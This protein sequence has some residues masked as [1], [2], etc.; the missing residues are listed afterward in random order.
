[1]K[2]ES[3]DGEIIILSGGG[4]DVLTSI[5]IGSPYRR[6]GQTYSQIEE[7][8]GLPPQVPTPR[9]A[10][11]MGQVCDG[12]TERR[13][14]EPK[15][16]HPNL[17]SEP[18]ITIIYNARACPPCRPANLDVIKHRQFSNRR[19]CGVVACIRDHTEWLRSSRILELERSRGRIANETNSG[20]TAKVQLL[21]AAV[22]LTDVGRSRGFML[23]KVKIIN[24]ADGDI[25][26]KLQY[27]VRLALATTINKGQGQCLLE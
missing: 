3:A 18:E 21:L 23:S 24:A 22:I 7:G 26:P 12:G 11:S 10:S 6:Q 13:T 20:P 1:M 14:P 2:T 17:K 15:K 16:F 9:P 8:T 19:L 5:F 27:L 25:S 4:G